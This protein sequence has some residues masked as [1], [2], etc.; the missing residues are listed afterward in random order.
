MKEIAHQLQSALGRA[1][2]DLKSDKSRPQDMHA[3]CEQV[4]EF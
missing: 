1:I 2:S 4:I 3:F